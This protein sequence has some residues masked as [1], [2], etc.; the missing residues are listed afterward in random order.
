MTLVIGLYEIQNSRGRVE[1]NGLK[2]WCR[3]LTV[4]AALTL[5]RS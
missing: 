5:L 1:A 3:R 4:A 2:S